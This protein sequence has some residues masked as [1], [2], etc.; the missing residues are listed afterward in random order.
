MLLKLEETK[1]ATLD[2]LIKWDPFNPRRESSCSYGD[3]HISRYYYKVPTGPWLPLLLCA[4]RGSDL[5]LSHLTR[6]QG[7]HFFDKGYVTIDR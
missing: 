7:T 4:H 6:D 3:Q 1:L 2:K 5:P